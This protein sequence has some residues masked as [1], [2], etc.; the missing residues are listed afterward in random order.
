VDGESF[1]FSPIVCQS[2]EYEPGSLN[3]YSCSSASFYAL[4]NIHMICMLHYVTFCIVNLISARISN[5]DYEFTIFTNI[6]RGAVYLNF[7]LTISAQP[8]GGID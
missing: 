7:E 2:R 4:I 1:L 3:A 8:S 5:I 6:S